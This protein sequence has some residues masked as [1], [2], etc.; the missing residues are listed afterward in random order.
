M[1]K[2]DRAM[3]YWLIAQFCSL[4][5]KTVDEWTEYDD[6]KESDRVTWNVIIHGEPRWFEVYKGLSAGYWDTLPDIK[7]DSIEV[8]EAVFE[9]VGVDVVEEEHDGKE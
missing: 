4:I 2:I 6:V 1:I 9:D 5:A 3:V 7:N 8:L